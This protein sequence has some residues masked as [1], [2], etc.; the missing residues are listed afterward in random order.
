[1]YRHFRMAAVSCVFTVLLAAFGLAGL[2]GCSPKRFA[3]NVLGDALSGGGGAFASEEDPELIREALP[4][5]LKTYESLLEISPEHEGLLLA[6]ARG[7]TAY[8]FLLQR[9]GDVLDATDLDQARHLRERANRLYLRGRDY[10]LRALELR[11]PGFGDALRKERERALARTEAEDVPCLYWGGAAWAGALSAAKDDLALIAEL[12]IAAAMVRRVLALNE[13]YQMGAAHE[14]FIAYEGGRPGG[15]RSKARQH[16]R[17]AV[18]LSGGLRASAHLALAESV[19]VKEQ[20][21]IE[22]RRLIAAAK[23]VDVD[24]EPE[25]RLVNVMA[26]ERAIWLESR[27][28]ELFLVAGEDSTQ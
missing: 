25:L 8:A 6:A 1:M 19:S 2:T 18:E 23:A 13:T 22:F 15:N 20:N 26:R 17:R 4:F 9:R 7:F 24:R 27:I 14:F 5:G 10:A 3:V 21:L 28:G 16:Y 12:P 11:Y